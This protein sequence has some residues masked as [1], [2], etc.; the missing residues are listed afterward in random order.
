[1]HQ[2]A[3]DFVL[4]LLPYRGVVDSILDRGIDLA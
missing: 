1:M 2:A 4:D 3:A